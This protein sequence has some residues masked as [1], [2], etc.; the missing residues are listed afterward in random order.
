MEN[1]HS[2]AEV[3]KPNVVDGVFSCLFLG[4]M[5]HL[6]LDFCVHVSVCNVILYVH[7]LY[8]CQCGMYVSVWCVCVRCVC[9]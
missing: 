7:A 2:V 8:V 3:R 6:L 5:M 9:I 1:I 4:T